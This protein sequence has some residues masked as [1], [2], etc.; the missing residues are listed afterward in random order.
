MILIDPQLLMFTLIGATKS[1]T[2]EPN[3]AE[4]RLFRNALPNPSQVPGGKTPAA[5]RLMAV[6]PNSS[7]GTLLLP[8]RF[9]SVTGPTL[10]TAPI[11]SVPFRFTWF[12]QQGSELLEKHWLAVL[13]AAA[14][15][16]VS[17]PRVGLPPPL[18]K[19]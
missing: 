3:D 8:G 14:V 4:A 10:L 19:S 11:E 5:V 7:A 18:V 17:S 15:S 9:G 13:P 16:H 1:L 2:S 12:P 6:S